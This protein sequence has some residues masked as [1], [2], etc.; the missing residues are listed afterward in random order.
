MGMVRWRIV[1]KLKE[2]FFEV[3][4]NHTYG[5]FTKNKRFECG[6]EKTQ[7]N[8]AEGSFAPRSETYKIVRVRR[9]NRSLEKFYA[10]KYQDISQ[11]NFRAEL[12]FSKK[13]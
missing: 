6:I 10:A 7:S 9:D 1:E 11:K 2:K 4:I 5:Y 13:R 3:E 12:N 8:I